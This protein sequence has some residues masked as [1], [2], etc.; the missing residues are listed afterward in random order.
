[1]RRVGAAAAL[2]LALGLA[3]AASAEVVAPGIADGM[4][5]LGPG[6]RPYVAYVHGTTLEVATRAAPGRWRRSTAASVSNGS[7]L[8]AFA[9]GRAGPV[10]L[11]QGA[12]ARTLALVRRAVPGWRMTQLAG[13]LPYGVTLGWPGLAL[14]RYGL[15]AIAY[16]RWRH[17]TEKSTL[18]LARVDARGRVRSSRLTALG[19][20]KSF[21][22]PPATPVVIG[23]AVHVIES[24]GVDG[25]VGTIEWYPHRRTWVGQFLDGGVGDYPVGPLL[26]ALDPRGKVY[27]AWSE[28]LLGTGEVPVTVAVHGSSIRSDFVLDR[29]LTTGLVAS[30]SGPE[31][32]ANEWRSASDLGLSGDAQLFA[33]DVVGHGRRVE[34]DG[35]L[36]GLA[37]AP[38]GARDLLLTGVSG[39]SWFRSPRPLTIRPSVSASSAATGGVLV[40]G[41]VRGATRGK[42]TIY[43]ERPGSSRTLAGT[44]VLTADGTFAFTDRP[45]ARPL[46][47]RA[48]YVDPATSIPYAALLRDPVR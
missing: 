42:V 20:P 37:K 10:A 23:G 25:A 2:V 16:T 4:L 48:V 31:V 7:T 36:A 14:D 47:Y 21:V 27:A 43:R 45:T 15:P 13:S 6:G 30:A 8:V 24:Y 33:G 3:G 26:A 11:V 39:L 22:A 32:A 38:K 9:V 46:L 18:Y 19:F 34:L 12:D 41:R 40:S 5:A 35:W 44:A 29:A 28:A 1:M 17:L